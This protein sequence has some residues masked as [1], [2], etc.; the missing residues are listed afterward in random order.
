MRFFW[1]IILGMLLCT[2]CSQLPPVQP[3]PADERPTQGQWE[4][5]FPKQKR[6]YIHSI[7]AV[8]A[9]QG[10]RTFMGITRVDPQT[11]DIRCNILTVEGMLLFDATLRQEELEIGHQVPPFDSQHFARGLMQDIQLV[12]FPP[13]GKIVARGMTDSQAPIR[14][15]QVSEQ[16]TIDLIVPPDN[17]AWILH[18][19]VD[20]KLVRSVKAQDPISQES[21]SHAYAPPRSMELTAHG[22]EMDYTLRMELLETETLSPDEG[23]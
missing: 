21:K 23:I 9:G 8:F 12:F 18:K 13:Q 17:Q 15:F 4:S 3:F 19:Y 6:L 20:A 22:E 5:K 14:R 10:R 2:A 7:Q 16:E 1:A 11:R